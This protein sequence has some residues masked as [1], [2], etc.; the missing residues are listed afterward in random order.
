MWHCLYTC[1]FYYFQFQTTTRW[2]HYIT[3]EPTL[4]FYM[5]AFM[6]TN[7]VEQTFYIFKAC[8]INHGYSPEICY[9]ISSNKTINSEVQ[10]ILN[11]F[12]SQLKCYFRRVLTLIM[13]PLYSSLTNLLSRTYLIHILSIVTCE[14]YY[15]IT[16]VLS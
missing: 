13:H 16:R 10:V 14:F 11:F 1:F 8:T 7:V 4:F 2:Y 6:I 15:F 9:D 12:Y 5:M 3:V